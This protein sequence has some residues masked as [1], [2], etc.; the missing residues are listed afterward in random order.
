MVFRSI[1][2][3]SDL[4]PCN[5]ITALELWVQA[6]LAFVILA[7]AEF[8]VILCLD[9][10]EDGDQSRVEVAPI[11]QSA[12]SLNQSAARVRVSAG[13]SA[14]RTRRGKRLDRV[15][16]VVFPAMFAVFSATYAAYYLTVK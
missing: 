7:V 15:S 6:C 16:L 5:S 14:K 1:G 10:E 3:T 11:G 12:P 2:L 4:P 9:E 13:Q 8:A